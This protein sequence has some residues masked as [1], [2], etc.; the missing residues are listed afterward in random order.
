M[1]AR[2]RDLDLHAGA[3]R[4]SA[5][6]P[7]S[8]SATGILPCT[9]SAPAASRPASRCRTS[10]MTW[11]AASRCA[12]GSCPPATRRVRTIVRTPGGRLPFQHYFVRDRCEP[13]VTGF[14]FKGAGDARPCGAGAGGAR[15]SFVAVRGRVSVQPLHQ[16]RPD[17]RGS[18]DARCDPGR[19]RAGGRGLA[20]RRGPRGEGSHREDDAPSSASRSR[21]MPSSGTTRASWMAGVIDSEDAADAAGFWPPRARGPDPDALRRGQ[22]R[23]GADGAGVRGTGFEAAPLRRRQGVSRQPGVVPAKG[24]RPGSPDNPGEGGGRSRGTGFLLAPRRPV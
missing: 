16:H 12:L 18:R 20:D 8:A 19:R 3:G 22:G 17:P 4:V 23:S 6:R 5:E 2:R 1:G 10:P 14:D 13:A 9:S 21:T 7:G 11:P 15:R 24:N